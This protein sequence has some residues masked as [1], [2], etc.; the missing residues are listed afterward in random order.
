MKHK[1]FLPFFLVGALVSS[2][3]S[4]NINKKT[5]YGFSTVF[6]INAYEFD[7]TS[8]LKI[9]ALIDTYSKLF[10]PFNSYRGIN[11]LKTI[12]DTKEEVVID[13][14]L[15]NALKKA[16]D[17]YYQTDKI[18]NP[19]LGNL[20]FAYKESYK[21]FNE[22]KELVLP[23]D[24]FI[25]KELNNLNSFELKFNDEN[26]SVQR[27]GD[28]K[29]DLGAF[30]KGYVIDELKY[31]FIDLGCNYYFINGGNSS[32]FFTSKPNGE[33]YTAGIK[34]LNKKAIEVKNSSLGISSIFEQFIKVDDIVYSHI[35]NPLTGKPDVSYDFSIVKHESATLTDVFST[36]MMVLSDK[37][38]I[39]YFKNKFGFSY[40]LFKEGL[41]IYTSGDLNLINY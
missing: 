23:T 12:N 10:D 9:E 14:K 5:I 40:S 20:T 28:S 37:E 41:E 36:V 2:C 26:L 34:Y 3:S 38:Q 22:T 24:A 15:F 11:N 4:F 17:F 31:Y 32:S 29:I 27:I 6:D 8:M 18:F 33:S 16:N 13:K 39:D 19:Y 35:I 25:S 1:L 21:K 30:A 7:D